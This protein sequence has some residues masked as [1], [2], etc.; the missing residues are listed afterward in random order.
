MPQNLILTS[1]NNKK[2]I[3]K[4]DFSSKEMKRDMHSLSLNVNDRSVK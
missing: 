2:P 1:P 4:N 3:D